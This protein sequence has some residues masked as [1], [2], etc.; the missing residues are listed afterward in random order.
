M[1]KVEMYIIYIISVFFIYGVIVTRAYLDQRKDLRYY[2]RHYD[3]QPKKQRRIYR[4]TT[5]QR[6][7]DY[8]MIISP[9]K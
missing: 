4:P 1:S 6:V 5:C 2:K 9:I 8:L 7:I 3:C